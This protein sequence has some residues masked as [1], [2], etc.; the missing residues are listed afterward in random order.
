VQLPPRGVSQC[1][2]RRGRLLREFP[3]GGGGS[4]G[5]ATRVV[6]M[7]TLASNHAGRAA[8]PEERWRWHENTT[9]GAPVAEL[10]QEGGMALEAC[11]SK[12][13][14]DRRAGVTRCLCGATRNRQCTAARPDS[15]V[16]VPHSGRPSVC[17]GRGWQVAVEKPKDRWLS[18]F[19]SLSVGAMRVSSA[20]AERL[21]SSAQRPWTSWPISS[22]TWVRVRVR[23]CGGGRGQARRGAAR[24]HRAA[25]PLG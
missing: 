12:C 21:S 7:A 15:L 2:R 13:T 22:S 11:V 20:L 4:A 25:W 3:G 18:N 5:R 14:K 24:A 16:H 23:A 9:T 17:C 1:S 6:R 10:A 19:R 8:K